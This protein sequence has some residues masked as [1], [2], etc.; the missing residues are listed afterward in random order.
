M[1][2]SDTSHLSNLYE[3]SII[4]RGS[5]GDILSSLMG[6]SG[7]HS[8]GDYMGVGEKDDYHD[9][10]D[11]HGFHDEED[12]SEIDMALS[13]LKKLS[14]YADK[15]YSIIEREEGLDGW[16]ASK[17]TRA[18]DY[19]SSVYHHLDF[20]TENDCGCDHEDEEDMY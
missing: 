1:K 9:H 2:N 19:I 10:E 4:A 3:N 6:G 13:D 15:L 8:S 11:D 18:S 14:E 17:I 12:P 5:V 20:E 7:E 16:V